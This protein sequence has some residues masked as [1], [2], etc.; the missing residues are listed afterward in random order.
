MTQKTIKL[1][2]TAFKKGEYNGATVHLPN[3]GDTTFNEDG[4]VDIP[5][6]HADFIIDA[7]KDFFAFKVFGAPEP[8]KS[9]LDL[10]LEEF[11]TALDAL[12]ENKLLELVGE[13][14]DL[15]FKMRVA[16]LSNEKIKDA[17]VEQYRK[18]ALEE[19]DHTPSDEPKRRGG[20]QKGTKNKPKPPGL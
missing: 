20:R 3:V 4:T 16:K 10:E 6:A 7:T 1:I 17:L 12:P 2:P 15:E 14:E 19:P 8:P 18:K 11:R 5:E 13:S 9:A